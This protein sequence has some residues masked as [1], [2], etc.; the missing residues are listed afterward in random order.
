MCV[1]KVSSF[2]RGAPETPLFCGYPDRRTDI[3]SPHEPQAPKTH[4]HS[5][6]PNLL[7]PEMAPS[8]ACTHS[9]HFC[10]AAPL[11]RSHTLPCSQP[12]CLSNISPIPPRPPTLCSLYHPLTWLRTNKGLRALVV[13]YLVFVFFSWYDYLT[14]VR[15]L[16][17]CF[18]FR[19]TPHLSK[20]KATS[21]TKCIDWCRQR[22]VSLSTTDMQLWDT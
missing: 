13:L 8:N 3:W 16:V 22:P 14:L 7:L 5:H 19:N 20:A 2:W 11:H 12:P 18:S 4:T 1:S 10:A 9:K 6:S 21:K 17:H 15:F